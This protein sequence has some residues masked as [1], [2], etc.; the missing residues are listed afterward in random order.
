MNVQVCL[1][2]YTYCIPLHTVCDGVSD[3]PDNGDEN[4]TFA[5]LGY[6]KCNVEN[7]RV[8]LLNLSDDIIHCKFPKDDE[9]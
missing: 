6:L 9:R 3:C 2:A 1:N 7:V 5:C 8:D 4:N